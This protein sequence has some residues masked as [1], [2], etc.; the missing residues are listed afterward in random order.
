MESLH[1]IGAVKQPLQFSLSDLA[2]FQSIPVR[3]NELTRDKTFHGVFNYRGV[4]L[5]EAAGDRG[6]PKRGIGL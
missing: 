6:G 2:R 1:I 3:L 4:S 5:K